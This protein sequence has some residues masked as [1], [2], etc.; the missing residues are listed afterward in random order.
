MNDMR[1]TGQV[2]RKRR[3]ELKLSQKQLADLVGVQ[4]TT[5]SRWETGSGYSDQG[6]ISKVATELGITVNDLLGLEDEEENL[7]KKR[8]KYTF[9]DIFYMILNYGFQ[10]SLI[11][12]IVIIAINQLGNYDHFSVTLRYT[13]TFKIV[14]TSI[15]L[16]I[17]VVFFFIKSA[18]EQIV[19]LFYR[20]KYKHKFPGGYDFEI[21]RGYYL[22]IN[23]ILLTITLVIVFVI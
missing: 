15:I 5:I 12:L 21:Q 1:I 22:F 6:T 18:K 16:S 4:P 3:I 9:K 8:K 19:R 2:I 11:V 7:N 13:K 14:V 23:V 10:V 20:A 17:D